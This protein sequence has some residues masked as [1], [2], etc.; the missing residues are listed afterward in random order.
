MNLG[1]SYYI[2]EQKADERAEHRTSQKCGQKSKYN[3]MRYKE[4]YRKNV[5]GCLGNLCNP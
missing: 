3:P 5:T 2:I 4:S 1:I